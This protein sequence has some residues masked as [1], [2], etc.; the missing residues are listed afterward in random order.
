MKNRFWRRKIIGM[1]ICTLMMGSIFTGLNFENEK[2]I[3]RAEDID[4]PDIDINCSVTISNEYLSIHVYDDGGFTGWTDSGEWI[5]YPADTSLFTV[6][7][8]SNIYSN[9][10]YNTNLNPYRTYNSYINPYN[11]KEVITVW[12]LP[13]GIHVEQHIELVG[14]QAKFRVY[15]RNDGSSQRTVSIRYLW[16]TQI[17][18]NDGA[19][20]REEGGSMRYFEQGFE[21]V[22]FNYWSAYARPDPGSLV[23]YASWDDTPDKIVFAHWPNAIGTSY[24]YSWSSSRRFY[25]PGYTYSPYSDS[26]VLMYWEDMTLSSGEGKNIVSYYGATVGGGID[27]DISIEKTFYTGNEELPIIVEVTDSDGNYIYPLSESDFEVLIDG[28]SANIID[29]SRYASRYELLVNAPYGTGGHSLTV[30]VDTSIGWGSDSSTIFV[31]SITDVTLNMG[32]N[33]LTRYQNSADTP[34]YYRNS[35][36]NYP[37]FDVDISVDGATVSQ[38]K[39]YIKV[40][41]EIQDVGLKRGE[42]TMLIYYNGGNQFSRNWHVGSSYPVGKYNIIAKVKD[43]QGNLLGSTSEKNFYLVFKPPKYSGFVTPTSSYEIR[44]TWGICPGIGP[45]GTYLYSLHQ[46]E[47]RNWKNVLDFITDEATDVTVEHVAKKLNRFAHGID[48]AYY[49]YWHMSRDERNSYWDPTNPPGGGYIYGNQNCG[50]DYAPIGGLHL[51][52]DDQNAWWY[53][54]NTFLDSNFNPEGYNLVEDRPTGLCADYAPLLISNCR[55]IGIPARELCGYY[56]GRDGGHAIVETYYDGKWNHFDPT[57]DEYEKPWTYSNEDW[58]KGGM[59]WSQLLTHKKKASC[60]DNRIDRKDNYNYRAKTTNIQFDKSDY[61]YPDSMTIDFDIKN[62]GS[63]EI[64]SEHL[65]LKIYDHPT[66]LTLGPTHLIS[67]IKI[68]HG[69]IEHPG[70]D[71][72]YTRSYDLPDY[73]LLNWVYENTPGFDRYII[74]QIEYYNRTNAPYQSFY[75]IHKLE[76]KIPGLCFEV[77]PEIEIDS[78]NV[79]L[80]TTNAASLYVDETNNESTEIFISPNNTSVH[81]EH[82][83]KFDRNYTK[84]NWHIFNPSDEVHNYSLSRP[85]DGIGNRVYI[86]G[87]GTI[88]TNQTLNINT[89]YIIIY[90]E[91]LGTDEFISA[92]SFSENLTITNITKCSNFMIAYGEMNVTLAA[93]S[94]ESFLIHYMRNG[95]GNTFDEV[96]DNITQQIY[97]HNDTFTHHYIEGQHDQIYSYLPN[98]TLDITVNISNNGE[99]SE[100]REFNLVIIQPTDLLDD[101]EE[102]IYND[103]KIVTVPAK[104]YALCTFNYQIPYDIRGKHKI[105]ISNNST[106]ST[107]SFIVEEPLNVEFEVP[108]AILQNKEFYV[109]ATIGNMVDVQ[110]SNINVTLVLPNVFNTSEDLNQTISMLDSEE[111]TTVSWKI[112]ATD[113]GYGTVPIYLLVDSAENMTTVSMI[114][115]HILKLPEILITS[116]I[117]SRVEVNVPFDLP[118]NVTNDGDVNLQ[119]V[120]VSLTLPGNVNASGDLIKSIG[121]LD[122]GETK[123]VNWSIT[124]A[125]DEDFC[126]NINARDATEI[127]NT[128]ITTTVNLI[129]IEF[130]LNL[131]CP[132]EV[133]INDEFDVLASV[134]NIGELNAT[135][136]L[137]NLS[138][139]MEFQTINSTSI[140]IGNLDSGQIKEISWVVKGVNPGLGAIRVNATGS[141]S[142]SVTRSVIVTHFPVFMATDHESYLQGDNVIIA[143]NA[144]NENSEVSFIDLLMN[145][146]IQGPDATETYS[147]PILY[148]G[149]LETKNIQFSW[150]TTG[151][152]YGIYTVTAKLMEGQRI[153]NET[154]ISFEIISPD[155]TPPSINIIAPSS[156][157][158]LQDG[159]TL[160]ALVSDP[161]GVDWVNFSIRNPDGEQ[162]TIIDDMFESMP[163]IHMGNDVWQLPFDTTLLPDGF[164]L[165]LVEACDMLGNQG[166]ET[167]NFS[168]RNWAVLEMLPATANHKAGR[169]I[170]VKFSI[171][172]IEAVDPSQPFVRNEE[173]NILIYEEGYP[174]DILQNS[175]FGDSSKDYRINSEDELYITNFKTSKKPKTYVVEIWRGEMLIGSFNFYT[176]K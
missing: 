21:P 1:L 7:V 166:N 98:D 160:D 50:Q 110:L 20:L 156:D 100:T 105:T 170:P 30:K 60:D 95:S 96:N 34:V 4:K 23:I 42:V 57:W 14:E 117:P 11:N 65:H 16:D 169:T 48:D 73:G 18:D 139:P 5:F 22:S 24:D 53:D 79:A 3:C 91:S 89:N 128:T 153:L 70:D 109:N 162:G 8:G 72:T 39:D 159:V 55:S 9:G 122:G 44:S 143:I 40:Y 97:S 27:V 136:V 133:I 103:T 164:Y 81:V 126:I 157:E 68:S 46:F 87:Y 113:V 83:T 25:T 147:I 155:N 138:L 108:I 67:D 33:R 152:P 19:P 141:D 77:N 102:I 99:F 107:T 75:T 63:V 119:N 78:V 175:T 35:N 173:L 58:G 114:Y 135:E 2:V 111:S 92:Y 38:I 62:T 106:K 151:K 172:V 69:Y 93:E 12:D 120:M 59:Y 116:Q 29:F 13:E 123:S 165:L 131:T 132:V 51:P 36:S 28:N 41:V 146:T 144:S 171:R 101:Y 49:G 52:W 148:V 10:Y 88:N 145:L 32:R 163:A 158:A 176:V 154:I 140:N 6:K 112:S 174:E 43:E 76:K 150:D 84:E 15:L 118:I 149:S 168:I 26:C 137:V 121:D 167:V 37:I 130:E 115:I 54:V 66:V 31:C 125:Y 142:V 80:N 56:E 129:K 71:H 45:W 127:Y 47:Y 17:A 94:G 161:S 90:N 104:S 61:D 85:L 74:A 134:E 86:P 64:K 124:S 82:K